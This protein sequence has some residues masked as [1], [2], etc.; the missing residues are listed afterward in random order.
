MSRHR[1]G[2]A[3]YEVRRRELETVPAAYV[4]KCRRTE[5]TPAACFS[6]C[7]HCKN[8]HCVPVAPGQTGEL[9]VGVPCSR[10]KYVRLAIAE[11]A[12]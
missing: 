2:P 12:A 3:L 10:F 5:G 11:G 9:V 4:P 7:P 8:A 1:R 6:P